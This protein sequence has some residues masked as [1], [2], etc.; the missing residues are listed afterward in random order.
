MWALAI[1]A[2]LIV[3]IG[4]AVAVKKK[5]KDSKDLDNWSKAFSIT[6]AVVGAL[7]LGFGAYTFYA[8]SYAQKQ[9]A[10]SSIYQEHMKLSYENP[11][12]ANGEFAPSPP[13]GPFPDKKTEEEEK[14]KFEKYQWYVGHALFSFEGIFDALPGDKGWESTAASF[15][16]GHGRYIRSSAFPCDHYSIEI[17]KFVHTV[18]GNCG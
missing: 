7:S 13:Q 4:V 1:G 9:L 15:I 2:I 3:L 10:A 5:I 8:S 16:K 17:Q 12:L 6:G 14:N 18:V 11:D